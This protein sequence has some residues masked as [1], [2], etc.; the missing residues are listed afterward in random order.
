[1]IE[2]F[3]SEQNSILL[4]CYASLSD[5]HSFIVHGIKKPIQLD[6]KM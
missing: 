5:L 6:N 1:M 3:G 2:D 4:K